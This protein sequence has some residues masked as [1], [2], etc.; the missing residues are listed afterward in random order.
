M[1]E[2]ITKKYMISCFTNTY[3][4]PAAIVKSH[5]TPQKKVHSIYPQWNNSHIPNPL[6]NSSNL[7]IILPQWNNV[8][9]LKQLDK[10]N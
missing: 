4:P 5:T 10:A 7:I 8:N 9:G 3:L 1:P 2:V 6:P